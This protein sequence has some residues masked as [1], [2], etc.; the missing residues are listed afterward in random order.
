MALKSK[1][2]ASD[3]HHGGKPIQHDVASNGAPD[4]KA[5]AR[6]RQAE[7]TETIEARL[8]RKAAS[9]DGRVFATTSPGQM[10]R[11]QRH[12]LLYGE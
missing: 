8:D 12:K 1:P 5:A 6:R 10:T 7:E 3:A 4:T 2:P 9:A 11:E